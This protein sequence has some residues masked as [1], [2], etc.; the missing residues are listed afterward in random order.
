MRA[1]IIQ[2]L[3]RELQRYNEV[4][5]CYEG[6]SAAFNRVDEWSDIDFQVVVK[7]DFVEKAVKVLEKALQSLSPIEDRLILPQ[8]TWHGHW[9]G[10]YKLQD[11]SPYLLIDAL[12]MKESSPSYFTEVELHGTPVIFFD[13]TGRL[14]K[15]HIDQK[16]LPNVLAKRVERIRSLSRMFHLL[17]DKEIKRRRE[18]D[19]FDLYYNLLLRSLIELLRIK[20]DSARW[21][22]GFRYLNSVLP[23][24]V[25][26]DIRNLSYARDLQD[27]QHKKD[28]VMQ[29]LDNLL[30]E[31]HP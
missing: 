11:A 30:Q 1:R 16:E 20:H 28:R 25:Y 21:S 26:E 14:G 6:G 4:L 22:W 12:I 27:L 18:P 10:F 2:S 13:K 5:G 8:P 9:Q 17:V 3:V 29:L 19:A 15:E 31:E 24:E 7:D 23:P